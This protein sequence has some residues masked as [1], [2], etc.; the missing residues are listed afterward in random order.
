[1]GS[2][3]ID[4]EKQREG[5]GAIPKERGLIYRIIGGAPRPRLCRALA[6]TGRD[7]G[8]GGVQPMK[9]RGKHT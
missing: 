9:E 5:T 2:L 3:T 8:S 4:S 6:T 1:M 7:V